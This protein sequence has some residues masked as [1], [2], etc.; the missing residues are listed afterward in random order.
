MARRRQL[1]PVKASNIKLKRAGADEYQWWFNGYRQVPAS[2]WSIRKMPQ[3]TLRAALWRVT[4]SR[5]QPVFYRTLRAAR[6]YIAS[7]YGNA[8]H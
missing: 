1:K 7:Q 5:T 8:Y 6:E 2:L 3:G 4:S